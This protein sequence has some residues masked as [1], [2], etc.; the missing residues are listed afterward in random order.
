[1]Y[2]I[3]RAQFLPGGGFALRT[4]K[5][6]GKGKGKGKSKGSGKHASNRSSPKQ[7]YWNKG[8]GWKQSGY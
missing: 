6:K 8:R 7:Q 1:M 3:A 4:R 5:G 2:S